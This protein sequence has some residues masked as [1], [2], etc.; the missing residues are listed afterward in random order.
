[1]NEM[2]NETDGGAA[3]GTVAARLPVLHARLGWFLLILT[4][5]IGVMVMFGV[6]QSLDRQVLKTAA[7]R[8]A[9]TG[10]SLIAIAQWVSWSGEPAQRSLVMVLFAA[11]LLWRKRPHPALVMLLVPPLAGVTSSLLKEAFG[12]ARP[13]LVPHL[14]SVTSL[15]YPSGHATNAMA[16]LLLAALLLSSKRPFWIGCAILGA[17]LIGISRI[18]LGVHW[19]SDVIGGFFWGAGMA[20]IGYSLSQRLEAGQN[21]NR[22]PI[23]KS[24]PESGA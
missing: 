1:M 23:L 3:A 12:R 16:I 5:A 15:S 24:R 17:V 4:I 7:F 9:V 21:A 11:W 2:E 8:Q 13:D 20:L 14:D 18:L 22:S 6:G 19:P 10:D